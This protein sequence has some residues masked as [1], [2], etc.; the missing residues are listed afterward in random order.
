MFIFI[1]ICLPVFWRGALQGSIFLICM[2]QHILDTALDMSNI[3]ILKPL[4]AHC[5]YSFAPEQ[6][7]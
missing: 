7:S 2:D 5:S 4:F 1:S 3:I 6:E